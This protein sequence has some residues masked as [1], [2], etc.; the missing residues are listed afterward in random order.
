MNTVQRSRVSRGMSRGFMY[1]FVTDRWDKDLFI[2]LFKNYV[3][4]MCVCVGVCTSAGT[5][6]GQ[7]AVDPPG[8]GVTGGSEPPNKGLR[9][10]S[11]PLA[12]VVHTF[13]SPT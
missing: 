10:N 8:A 11:S 13:C 12:R 5:C 9:L 2:Y 6:E 7:R 1:S 3:V 4:G